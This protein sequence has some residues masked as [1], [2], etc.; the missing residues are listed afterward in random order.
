MKEK[1][2]VFPFTTGCPGSIFEILNVY[3]SETMHFWPH[4]GEAKMCLGCLSFFDFS[5]VC[6]QFSAVCLKFLRIT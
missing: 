4:V 1:V 6:L 3:N 2:L 5:A